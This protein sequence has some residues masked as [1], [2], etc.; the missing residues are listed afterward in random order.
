MK[1]VTRVNARLDATTA[2]ILQ[3]LLVQ[4][5]LSASELISRSLLA[6]HEQLR[7]RLDRP[8]KILR[9]SGFIGCA[10]GESDLSSRYKSLL[11]AGFEKKHG[12]R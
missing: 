10:A 9:D 12:H 5:S 1:K 8:S 2:D 4:T 3:R 6:Y 11:T 7:T